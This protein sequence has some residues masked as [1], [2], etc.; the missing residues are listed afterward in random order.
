ML[1]TKEKWKKS[2]PHPSSALPQTWK[3]KNQGTLSACWE[4]YHWLHE[5]SLFQN[6]LSP[7]LAWAS[8]PAIN[9]G[10]LFI[11]YEP[12]NIAEDPLLRYILLTNLYTWI[13][14]FKITHT[15]A[16]N[17]CSP[18]RKHLAIGFHFHNQPWCEMPSCA[19]LHTPSVPSNPLHLLSL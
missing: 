9:W 16:G 14:V 15:K 8:N 11:Y 1:G 4:P 10:Y 7:F 12:G 19:P 5:I 17:T 18:Y 13:L 6:C 2:S 3:K